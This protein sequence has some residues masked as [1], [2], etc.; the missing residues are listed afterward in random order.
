MARL[1]V[2]TYIE[3]TP[4]RKC[5]AHIHTHTHD[6]DVDNLHL[7]ELLT[8]EIFASRDV[9]TAR[10]FTALTGRPGKFWKRKEKEKE[11]KYRTG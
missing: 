11:K 2:T 5:A 1:P 4:R 6:P 10:K 7:S 8:R 3:S 9:F